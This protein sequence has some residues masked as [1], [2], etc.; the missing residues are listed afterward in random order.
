MAWNARTIAE[1][2]DWE[3]IESRQEYMGLCPCHEPSGSH[4]QNAGVKDTDKGI[5][6]NCFAGC[7]Y[8]DFVAAMKVRGVHRE[9]PRKSN[10][11][12]E[13]ERYAYVDEEGETLYFNIRYKNPKTF[14][15]AVPSSNGLIYSTK[16]LTR[17]VVYRLPQI[18]ETTHTI[19]FCE[20]E[21]D[22][23]TLERL[24]LTATCIAGGANAWTRYAEHYIKQLAGQDIVILP[25]NDAAGHHLCTDIQASMQPIAKRLR[26]L[27][28][29]GVPENG[30]D[31][32][33]WVN[34][35][36]TAE[37][38]WDLLTKLKAITDTSIVE[39]D[40]EDLM[41]LDFPPLRWFAAGLVCE[42]M[43]IV[44][45]KSKVGKSW[46]MLNVAISIATGGNVFGYYEVPIPTKVL[47]CSLEDGPRRLKRRLS[48]IEHTANFK[49]NLK[50]SFKMPALEDGGTEYIMN[51]IKDGYEVIIVDVMAHV[52]KSGK[53]GLRDYHEVYRQFAPLQALRSKYPF[54]LILVTHLRKTESEDIFN[55]LHGSVA[56]QGTQDTLWVLEK[57]YGEETA[58]LHIRSK[59]QEDKIAELKF[60]GAGV[61]SFVG[62]GEEHASSKIEDS[63]IRYLRDENGPQGIR[64]IMRGID[65]ERASYAAFK[66]RLSR[67]MSKGLVVR[68]DRGK[69]LPLR[70][71]DEDY[72][73]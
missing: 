24:G 63:I 52:E 71:E 1:N 2:L 41:A 39:I 56:Y 31:V 42:G 61:W 12:E 62:E 17:R 73:L 13:V 50:L 34:A 55:D 5:L 70:W 37:V 23:H 9:K 45:G 67:M 20:G 58:N 51:H 10:N 33:D 64:D 26:V 21:K 18:L 28:L 11:A 49:R 19:F 30:G 60:D 38:L 46:L 69:Y 4:E 36:G 3:W 54:C 16:S 72:P 15:M 44:G 57:K 40:A 43:G 27:E 8:A 22:V 6:F 59:D 25:H 66:M 35:G 7:T 53:N 68:T 48:M 32:T 29:P 65:Q 14:K 47:Y